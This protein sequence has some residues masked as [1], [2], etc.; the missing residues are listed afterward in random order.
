MY[1]QIV[2]QSA[3]GFGADTYTD[4]GFDSQYQYDGDKFSVTVKLTDI[5]EYQRLNASFEPRGSARLELEQPP[6][7]LQGERLFRLGSHL[8]HRRRLFQ[9][10]RNV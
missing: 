6:Q 10:R 4:I 7:Q 5:P 3:F 9:R 2:P 1:G 8:Q